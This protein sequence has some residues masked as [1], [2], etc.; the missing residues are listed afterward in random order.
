[1]FYDLVG[2]LAS[3]LSTYLFIRVDRKAWPIGL[4]ATCINGFLYWQKGIYGDMFLE[5]FYFFSLGYGWQQWTSLQQEETSQIKH[6][7]LKQWL[8]LGLFSVLM[9]VGVYLLLSR[10]SPSTVPKTDALTTSLSLIAQWL[11]CRQYIATWLLWL[12][13]DALYAGLYWSKGLVFHT[14]LM[15]TY[16]GMAIAGFLQWRRS[17]GDRGR[18]DRMATPSALLLWCRTIIKLCHI[19]IMHIFI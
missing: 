12:I 8:Y 1:M 9:T 18:D 15:L 2:G 5:I 4:I 6:L 11:M 19:K 17:M 3:L 13:T 14:I 7:S 10:L 16:T